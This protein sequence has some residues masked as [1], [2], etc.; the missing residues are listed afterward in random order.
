[1][2]CHRDHRKG[3]N[4]V[5]SGLLSP[6]GELTIIKPGE[7]HPGMRFTPSRLLA[8]SDAYLHNGG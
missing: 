2:K 6:V 8:G 4:E 5:S 7:R 1:M 3:D